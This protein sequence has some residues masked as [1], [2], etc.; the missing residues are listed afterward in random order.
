M[1]ENS[2]PAVIDVPAELNITDLLERQ[3]D[4]DPENILF[5]RN[6]NPW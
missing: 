5:G 3:A 4:A 2:V 1:S 6:L